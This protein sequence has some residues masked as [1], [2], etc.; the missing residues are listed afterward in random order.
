MIYEILSTLI[1]NLSSISENS[2]IV[3][4]LEKIRGFLENSN[5]RLFSAVKFIDFFIHDM[6]DFSMLQ[7]NANFMKEM[8]VHNIKDAVKEIL[9]ILEAKLTF[10]SIH[11]DLI[12]ENLG[13]TEYHVK[14]DIKRM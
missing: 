2:G 1:I 10:K 11:V 7:K 4:I 8:N 5:Q 13:E 9:E 6:L 14:T 12:Y 3:Q